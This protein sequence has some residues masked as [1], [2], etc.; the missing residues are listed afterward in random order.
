MPCSC[1]DRWRFGQPAF[2]TGN[3]TDGRRALD[4]AEA[5]VLRE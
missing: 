2:N 3:P 5:L 4:H 1:L